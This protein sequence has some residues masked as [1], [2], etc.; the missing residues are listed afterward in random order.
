MVL[1]AAVCLV[2]LTAAAQTWV[3]TDIGLLGGAESSDARGIND[4]GTVVGNYWA[5]GNR[6]FIWTGGSGWTDFSTLGGSY[7]AASGVNN[8]NQ[9]TG[10]SHTS[11]DTAYH[12]FR[13]TASTGMQ[14]IGTLGGTNSYGLGINDAGQIVGYSQ[15]TGNTATHAFLWTPGSGML[16]L[17][18]L[19]GPTAT[20]MA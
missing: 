4:N 20:R 12:A 5:G 6:G 18:T 10:Y 2:P 3:P 13:W 1:V 7:L 16:D 11:G 15:T 9:V 8:A 19:G 17:G 14:D